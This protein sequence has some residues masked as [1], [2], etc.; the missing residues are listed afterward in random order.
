MVTDAPVILKKVRAFIDSVS[1]HELGEARLKQLAKIYR[2]P[3]LYGAEKGG[4]RRKA[5]PHGPRVWFIRVTMGDLPD[6]F[7]HVHEVEGEKARK[8]M[9][10]PRRHILDDFWWSGPC[11][12]AKG[13]IVVQFVHEQEQP[14]RVMPPGTVLRTV[15]HTRGGQTKTFVYLEARD[16]RKKLERVFAKQIGAGVRGIRPGLLGQER[17][18]RVLRVWN[19]STK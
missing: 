7:E 1:E 17:A 15:K 14:N 5:K 9:E 13:D 6:A 16:Q 18:A 4:S 10:H 2:P 11:R 12:Y 19:R 3:K 8:Q